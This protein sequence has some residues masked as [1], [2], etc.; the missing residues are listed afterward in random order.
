MLP[1]S[2]CL[3]WNIA[4]VWNYYNVHGEGR[5]HSK[6]TKREI[7]WTRNRRC[8]QGFG[9]LISFKEIGILDD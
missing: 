7:I 8:L 3:T 9:F 6:G 5:F 4:W 1:Q 2:R